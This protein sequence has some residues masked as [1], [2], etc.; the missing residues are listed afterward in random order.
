[1]SGF[2]SSKF[3]KYQDPER[4]APTE[5]SDDILLAGGAGARRI[6]RTGFALAFVCL[7]GVIAARL[8]LFVSGVWGVGDETAR[9]YLS[10]GLVLSVLWLIGTWLT[11]L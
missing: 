2:L 6:W 11:K 8:M 4:P 5:S 10:S 9:M 7:L 3:L 1:M